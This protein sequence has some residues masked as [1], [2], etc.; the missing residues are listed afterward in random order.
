[1]SI[2]DSCDASEAGAARA[3]IVVVA[4][5]GK[6]TASNPAATNPQMVL[7]I[8]PPYPAERFA[9]IFFERRT[10]Y[11][12]D[13]TV[14]PMPGEAARGTPGSGAPSKDG[15]A[16]SRKTDA[17]LF[18]PKQSGLRYFASGRATN[19]NDESRLRFAAIQL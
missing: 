7:D 13:V 8:S 4:K 1:M 9:R 3:P 14:F 18:S 5:I 15:F 11:V 10:T 6:E 19:R 2:V 16:T 17:Q 12:G